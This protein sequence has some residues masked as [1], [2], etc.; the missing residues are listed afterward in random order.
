MNTQ[1]EKTL[2]PVKLLNLP[3]TKKEMIML[4]T[5]EEA[6]QCICPVLYSNKQNNH[7]PY[8]RANIYCDADKCMAWNNELVCDK[9]R[10]YHPNRDD[11]GRKCSETVN[12]CGVFNVAMNYDKNCAGNIVEMGYCKLIF[13]DEEVE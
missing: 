5:I 6:K 1:K 11:I 8:T 2:N 4:R 7:T 12:S 9:C 10:R 3:K 13:K